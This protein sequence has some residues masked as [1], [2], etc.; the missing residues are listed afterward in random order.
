MREALMRVIKGAESGAEGDFSSRSPAALLVELLKQKASGTLTLTQGPTVRK[1][2]MQGGQVR[3]AQ[4]NVKA[5]TAGAA[6]VA[7]GLIK[8]ATFDRAVADARGRKVPLHEALAASRVLTPDQLKAALKQQTL[9]VSL[10][11]L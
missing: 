10:G 3:F 11:A 2:T 7:S 6:Q 9:E 5:E 8:Q 1:L 4:S